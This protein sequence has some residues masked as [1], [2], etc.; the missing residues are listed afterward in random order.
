MTPDELYKERAVKLIA[1]SV[2]K[3]SFPVAD[4]LNA[5]G[6]G[7]SEFLANAKS[8]Y[9]NGCDLE[10]NIDLHEIRDWH[11]KPEALFS[12]IGLKEFEHSIKSARDAKIIA[13]IAIIISGFLALASIVVSI[14]TN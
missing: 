4:A 7:L 10:E 14:V 5:S 2:G 8:V 12:Y 13:I 1:F 11:L 3:R 6:M 9:T